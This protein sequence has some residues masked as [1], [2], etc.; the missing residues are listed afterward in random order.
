MGIKRYA[1]S[2]RIKR[3]SELG[4]RIRHPAH[5]VPNI[6]EERIKFVYKE[7]ASRSKGLVKKR[8]A[9]RDG[10]EGKANNTLNTGMDGL[11]TLTTQ[12]QRI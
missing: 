4:A 6:Y 9:G 12:G 8:A 5:A 7:R 11:E 10:M 1:R 2:K 3:Y